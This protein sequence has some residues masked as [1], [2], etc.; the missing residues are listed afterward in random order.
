MGTGSVSSTADG[1]TFWARCGQCDDP[2]V[3]YWKTVVYDLSPSPDTVTITNTWHDFN[4]NNIKIEIPPF[5][6]GELPGNLPE[7]IDVTA[8]IDNT[9]IALVGPKDFGLQALIGYGLRANPGY[10]DK[11]NDPGNRNALNG[12]T[13]TIK[14]GN[15]ERTVSINIENKDPVL[16]NFD[17][18]S[19]PITTWGN[20][21]LIV[22]AGDACTG[23]EVT[24]EKETGWLDTVGSWIDYIVQIL[25]RDPS[26]PRELY[27]PALAGT[28]SNTYE[29]QDGTVTVEW[30][31]WVPPLFI[32]EI[33]PYEDII[34]GLN[35]RFHGNIKIKDEDDNTT[36]KPF[37][38][39]F[40]EGS[41]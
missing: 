2:D 1:D 11:Y 37:S 38:I 35:F 23:V 36:T 7:D 13:V 4:E 8:S 18:G 29:L 19:D 25:G 40:A 24:V 21:C 5:A 9:D 27:L 34:P 26:V 15:L 39:D 16:L 12:G 3:I 20:Y 10:K 17:P 30:A 14:A 32:N 31:L 41:D 33:L 22:N 6:Y 28:A